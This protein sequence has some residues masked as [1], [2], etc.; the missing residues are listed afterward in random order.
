MRRFVSTVTLVIVA[1]LSSMIPAESVAGVTTTID[2]QTRIREYVE[3]N[4]NFSSDD[5]T[6]TFAVM[7]TRLGFSLETGGAVSGYLQLQ[8]T[9]AFGEPQNT[10]TTLEQVDLHQGFLV[11]ENVFPGQTV[12]RVGRTEM[13]YFRQR[14]VG[15]VG[16]NDYG[17]SFDGARFE[18][19]VS[20]KG[21][22]H[23]FAMKTNETGF[24][25][26]GAGSTTDAGMGRETAFFGGYFHLDVNDETRAEVY[27]FDFHVDDGDLMDGGG[28]VL[29]EDN[30]GNLFT[31]G[32]TF[33]Y[34]GS[35]NGIHV[36]GE[37]AMQ[38]GSTPD[39]TMEGDGVDYAGWAAYG[40]VTYQLP[41]DGLKPYVG[42]EV[43]VASGD[44]GSDDGETNDYQQLF[45]TAH[46]PL[47]YQDL[48]SWSNIMEYN[49]RLGM[50]P[51]SQWHTYADFHVFQVNEVAG[52]WYALGGPLFG[53]PRLSGN[54]D[55][56]SALGNE[57]DVVV[58]YRVDQNLSF[59]AKFALWMPGA[60]QEQAAAAAAAVPDPVADPLDLDSRSTFWLQTVANF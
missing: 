38:F 7:R 19:P 56:D 53:A 54:A 37:G 30:T 11:I 14:Q 13:N 21:W 26:P 8:D 44:D 51:T 28:A 59:L 24:S 5:K 23:A 12:L 57:L 4:R 47:G 17:R 58:T 9:R 41:G 55:F 2:G 18:I 1:A 25:T 20:D 35:D 36:Y 32:A 29:V 16:W 52:N 60:W 49:V 3:M 43:N 45:P 48:V 33:D 27:V 46:A 15:A 22:F 40:G 10:L 34:K 50:K 42:V 39:V 6:S 31:A